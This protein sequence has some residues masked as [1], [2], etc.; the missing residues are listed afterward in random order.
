MKSNTR[1]WGVALIVSL[2]FNTFALG[3][4]LSDRFAHRPFMDR[5]P[6]GT[7]RFSGPDQSPESQHV[8]ELF[9][10][11]RDSNRNDFLPL[12]QGIRAARKQVREA[13]SAEPFD[14][15]AL[16]AALSGVRAAEQ[17]AAQHAHRSISQLAAQ[18]TH[19]ERLRL[20]QMIRHHRGPDELAMPG[21]RPPPPSRDPGARKPP[22]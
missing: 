2:M 10:E 3:L 9:Q 19:D 4:L 13:M 15:A 12:M 5:M 1:I 21:G 20:G 7:P 18:L 16:D 6:P 17:A 14:P 8:R 22:E 11:L